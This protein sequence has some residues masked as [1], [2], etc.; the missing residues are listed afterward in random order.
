MEQKGTRLNS[1]QAREIAQRLYEKI[2]S[3]YTVQNY[4]NMQARLTL[5]R[6]RAVRDRIVDTIWTRAW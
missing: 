3:Y 1:A 6:R 4:G 5:L 2:A